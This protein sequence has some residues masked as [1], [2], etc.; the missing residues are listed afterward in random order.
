MEENNFNI[1]DPVSLKI[2]G[3]LDEEKNV[4]TA[5]PIRKHE[6]YSFRHF[7]KENFY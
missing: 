1:N 5:K 6:S 3:N 4:I 7:N 2:G